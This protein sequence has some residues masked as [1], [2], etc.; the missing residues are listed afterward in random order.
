MIDLRLTLQQVYYVFTYSD[1]E[2]LPY[3]TEKTSSSRKYVDLIKCFSQ[4]HFHSFRA[5]VD[6]DI[7]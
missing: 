7:F 1:K 4:L 6:M 3:V 2:I 5:P